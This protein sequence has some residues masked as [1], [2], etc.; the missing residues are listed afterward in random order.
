MTNPDEHDEALT[1][2]AEAISDHHPVN[3]AAATP[4]GDPALERLQM[5]E[6]IAAAHRAG[7][8]AA[9]DGATAPDGGA[10]AAGHAG[11]AP[12]PDAAP[13]PAA[14]AG[15]WG[16]FRLIERLSR[17]SFGEVYRAF[18]PELQRE[19]AI[20]LRRPTGPDD[21]HARRWIEE[22]RRL[23]RPPIPRPRSARVPGAHSG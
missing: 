21:T 4:T 2:L 10:A 22:A 23:G 16:P 12:A 7:R 9:D 3:W 14:G 11:S 18:D 1:R 20:K 17:G 15:S 13:P 8:G 6:A 5:I 19:V